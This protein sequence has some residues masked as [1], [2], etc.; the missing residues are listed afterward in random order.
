MVA[1]HSGCSRN[2]RCRSGLC[3]VLPEST[4]DRERF[5]FAGKGAVAAASLVVVIGTVQSC[6]GN[7]SSGDP[8]WQYWTGVPQ[9]RISILF[10]CFI[11][12]HRNFKTQTYDV[13]TMTQLKRNCPG[14]GI[15]LDPG[16]E[17]ECD[18]APAGVFF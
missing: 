12:S 8:F 4:G 10:F 14:T 2:H 11:V 5:K 3:L 1:D 18:H 6:D 15:H 7:R 13:E 16:A 9:L 17:A